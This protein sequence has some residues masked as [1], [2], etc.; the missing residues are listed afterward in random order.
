MIIHIIFRGGF[1][2][3]WLR[4][5]PLLALRSYVLRVVGVH[6]VAV[7]Y[8]LEYLCVD[9]IKKNEGLHLG[10]VELLLIEY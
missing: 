1:V 2:L 3:Q 6:D 8:K 4:A 9:A 10:S 5:R 7:S